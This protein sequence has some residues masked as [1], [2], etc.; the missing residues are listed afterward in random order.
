MSL[1]RVDDDATSDL[2]QS[3]IRHLQSNDPNMMPAEALR[4]SMME[5]KKRRPQPM[6]WASF[7]L[8]GTPR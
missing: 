8:F 2:M 5:V 4:Q 3:F 1:W 6:Q 7:V